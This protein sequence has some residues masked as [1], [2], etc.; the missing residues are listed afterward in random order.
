MGNLR[1]IRGM[2]D[3]L[4]SSLLNTKHDNYYSAY[5]Y[6]AE[7]TFEQ[8]YAMYKRNS[9][10]KA[11]CERHTQKCW[12][13]YPA[14]TEDN[15][16]D[17]ES[18]L[19][20]D[21]RQRFQELRFWS[22]LA[23]ADLRSRVGE[24][25]AVVLRVADSKEMNQPVDTVPGGLDGLV[26]VIPCWQ[27]QLTVSSWE[28][29]PE[30]AAYGKP[31]M[32]QFNESAVDPQTGKD[33]SFQVHPDRVII[34]SKDGTTHGTSALEAPFNALIDAE[35]IRGSGGEGFF[36]A[37]KGTPHYKVDKEANLQQLA[38]MLG[39]E[40][41]ADIQEKMGEISDGVR[42][43]FDKAMVTQGIEA[44]FMSYQVPNPQYFYQNA[45]EE[46]AA[47][48]GIP[49]K[50][51]TGSQ[52]GERASTEDANEW[53]QTNQSRRENY[54][55]P[56]IMQVINRLERFRILPERDWT[57]KWSDLTES[58]KTDKIS[59]SEKMA[60]VNK[61][62]MGTGEPAPFSAAEIRVMAGYSPEIK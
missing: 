7:L 4:F 14:L 56:N 49:L 28:T 31:T 12:Q 42:Q 24:Y 39:A 1:D 27:G 11:G 40:S 53:N 36:Q 3:G 23:Q 47:G 34:W 43:G 10:A 2:F 25:A 20:M 51:L 59:L 5:G 45:K 38:Q 41:P 29:R 15:Q 6:P 21:I 54:V 19:E 16:V 60:N 58:T 35:K 17:D 8:M 18:Q 44:D 50:I 48:F 52:S 33:R 55:K 57:L 62:A 26:E 61:A 22:A 32:Y 37:A 13:D 30:Q 46:I 9:L